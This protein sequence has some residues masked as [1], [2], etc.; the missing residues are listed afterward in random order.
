[1]DRRAEERRFC[2][3]RKKIQAVFIGNDKRKG[4]RRM[5]ERRIKNRRSTTR[6]RMERRTDERRKSS[7]SRSNDALTEQEK[8][9]LLK[10]CGIN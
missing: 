1:M 7:N 9:A 2:D 6:R 4:E 8:E 5:G 10:I 3:R